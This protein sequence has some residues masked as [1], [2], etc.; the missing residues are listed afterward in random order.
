VLHYIE[1]VENI[2]LG[3]VNLK[4]F[5][6]Y[7]CISK[8]EVEKEAWSLVHYMFVTMPGQLQHRVLEAVTIEGSE[9]GN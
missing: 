4:P 9:E 7:K 3:L 2:R 5:L 1:K 6:T 8:V